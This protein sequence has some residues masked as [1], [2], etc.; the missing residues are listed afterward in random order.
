L[1]YSIGY[2]N[3]KNCEDLIEILKKKGIGVLI[4][5]RSKPYSRKTG[6][7]K[8]LIS[9]K[10][11]ASNIRY[12]WLGET[13]GGFGKINEK[14]IE[15]LAFFQVDEQVCIMCM[16]ADPEKCHRKFEIAERLK[17]YKV[18]VEHIRT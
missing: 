7:N 13:L 15:S 8:T 5:V 10:L 4:D 11:R 16:E 9:R 2:Q 6:F 18:E 14:S 1:I 3:L 17:Q 12:I